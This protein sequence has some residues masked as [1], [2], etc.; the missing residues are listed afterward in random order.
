ME[1]PRD[2]TVAPVADQLL[3]QP[4]VEAAE[5]PI[6]SKRQRKKQLRA[7]ETQAERQAH[8]KKTKKESKH[9]A[10]AAAAGPQTAP[11]EYTIANGACTTCKPSCSYC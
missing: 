9:A 8:R 1:T 11:A 3:E 7:Q 6:L 2:A 4:T 10:A 5:A